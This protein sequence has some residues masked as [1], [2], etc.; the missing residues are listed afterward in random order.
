MF[1]YFSIIFMLLLWL[2]T[3][4]ELEWNVSINMSDR[5][6]KRLFWTRHHAALLLTPRYINYFLCWTVVLGVWNRPI[7][8]ELSSSSSSCSY[9]ITPLVCLP[10]FPLLLHH[11]FLFTPSPL[12]FTHRDTWCWPHSVFYRSANWATVTDTDAESSLWPCWCCFLSVCYCVLILF[13]GRNTQQTLNPEQTNRQE[14]LPWTIK[15]GPSAD[16]RARLGA[17]RCFIPVVTKSK[18]SPSLW[19]GSWRPAITIIRLNIS[20]YNQILHVFTF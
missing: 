2:Q 18:S 7:P 10:P 11:T 3:L 19:G 15:E 20:N 5:L 4:E 13:C 6:S 12:L 17:F 9:A 16:Q 8:S 1:L 14:R